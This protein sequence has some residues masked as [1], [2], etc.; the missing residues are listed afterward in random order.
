MVMKVRTVVRRN[1]HDTFV[2]KVYEFS[3]T[4][5]RFA[6]NGKYQN[7]DDWANFDE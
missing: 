1:L 7:D 4:K 3:R 2:W 6:A 5:A